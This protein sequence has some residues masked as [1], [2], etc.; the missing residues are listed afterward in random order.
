MVETSQIPPPRQV[1]A[2]ALETL[3]IELVHNDQCAQETQ[4]LT[5]L[6]S[7]I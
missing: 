5:T 1:I 7:A 3:E 2:D 6:N 4:Y